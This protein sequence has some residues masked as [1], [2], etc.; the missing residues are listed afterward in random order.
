LA[1]TKTPSPARPRSPLGISLSNFRSFGG[2][3]DGD[4]VTAD[5]GPLTILLGPNGAG[6]SSFF[7]AIRL[8]GTSATRLEDGLD[9][10]L[11]RLG[12]FDEVV[13]Q[14]N[15]DKLREIGFGIR[16]EAL[17]RT[18]YTFSIRSNG[19]GAYLRADKMTMLD[20]KLTLLERQPESKTSN[21]LVWDAVEK[22]MVGYNIFTDRPGLAA[23]T[24]DEA[25]FPAARVQTFLKGMRLIR[26]S[27]EAL[28]KPSRPDDLP[29]LSE[30]GER[31]ARH[32]LE[33]RQQQLSSWQYISGFL[34]IGI[35]GLDRVEPIVGS[36]GQ[37]N[38][39]GYLKSDRDR[40]IPARQLS[41]GTLLLL[42]YACLCFDPRPLPTLL[43]LEEP[44]RGIHAR[45]QEMVMQALRAASRRTVV[46]ISTH[47][48]SLLAEARLEELLLVEPGP[49]GVRLVRPASNPA[50]VEWI[51]EHGLGNAYAAGLL[52]G[53]A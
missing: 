5:L 4:G 2:A 40:P 31:L 53:G 33:I 1:R 39:F 21:L 37:V 26:F 12:G 3:P 11:N 30:T 8:L 48:P 19:H 24:P 35:P 9:A 32:A 23:V 49:L 13:H 6:K 34:A 22:K 36:D 29:Y 42:A 20:H 16:I 28:R 17:D 47:S 27:E 51:A 18:T 41:S 44:D 50:L 52:G 7:D 46:V 25:R 14:P 38:L 43:M 10:Q 15:P 45:L